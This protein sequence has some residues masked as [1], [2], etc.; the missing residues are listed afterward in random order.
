LIIL[1]ES[2]INQIK[3]TNRVLSDLLQIMNIFKIFGI[4]VN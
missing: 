1:T 4:Y 2:Y 3:D